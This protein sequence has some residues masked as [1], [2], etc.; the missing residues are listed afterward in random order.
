[1]NIVHDLSR[2][3]VLTGAGISA[4]SGLKTFR[5]SDGLWEGYRV[6]D[7][8]T[9]E[10]WHR[11]KEL[12][13]RF[14]EERRIQAGN[15]QPNLAHRQ[16][17]QLQQLYPKMKIVTQNVDDLHERGGATEV[18]HIH[19]TLFRSRSVLDPRLTYPIGEEGLKPG[20]HCGKGAQLR[21][22]IVWFGEAVPLMEEAVLLAQQ[23]SEFW[24]IGTSL[25]VYPAASLYE[26]V[27]ESCPIVL[28]D[29]GETPHWLSSQIG[30]YRFQHLQMPATEGVSY[31]LK[32]RGISFSG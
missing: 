5:G 2:L 16:L 12:V 29:P 3:V 9:P 27:P 7:V 21:P 6:E 8:A 25:L 4:E 22:D 1:M 20:H 32:E 28:I 30:E 11:N 15:A 10:A 24:I 17:G 23:A 19:G 13:L 26:F 14:Y 18:L 31:L